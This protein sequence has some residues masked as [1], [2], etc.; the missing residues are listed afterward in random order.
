MKN[1]T[2]KI[3]QWSTPE[4]LH[5]ACVDWLSQLEFIKDE[6]RFLDELITN[7]TI[8]LISASSY[9]ASLTV[10]GNLLKEENELTEL[11]ERVKKHINTIEILLDEHNDPREKLAFKETHYYLKTTMLSYT[12]KYRKTK[13]AL[14]NEIKEIMKEQ[15]PKKLMK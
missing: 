12:T 9:D 13:S 11:I 5:E 15:P 8:P 4:E 1:I 2:Y 14:F 7:Y 3:V 6:Q 10:V